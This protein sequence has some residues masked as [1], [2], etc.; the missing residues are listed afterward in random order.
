LRDAF[1]RPFINIPRYRLKS[2]HSL[3]HVMSASI[4]DLGVMG[5]K[6]YGTSRD[7]GQFAFLLFSEPDGKLLAVIEA[8]ALGQIRTGAASGLATSLLAS[9]ESQ[10]AA[11]IGTG[12]QAE[13]QL[14]AIDAVLKLKQVRVYSRDP[15]NREAFIQKMKSATNAELTAANS[16]EECV[17]GADVICTITNSRDPV[18]SGE[19]LKEGCHINAAGSNWSN[20]RELDET[21]VRRCAFICVDHVEQSRIES[22]DLIQAFDGQDWDRVA[23][24]SEVVRGKKGRSSREQITLF[25]SHGIAVEDV[26]AAN[27][28]YR[29]LRG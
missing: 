9:S 25:K 23:E 20:K 29:K 26:A 14:R 21:A 6:S 27:Y 10:V 1:A 13:T 11:I 22:G 4:P 2:E 16:A 8:D 15:K 3:L 18:V 17:R 28:I 7:G 5:V 19:W 24:L 12:F